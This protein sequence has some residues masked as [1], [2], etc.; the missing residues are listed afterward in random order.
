MHVVLFEPEIPANTGNI[1]RLCVGTGTK[2]HLIR[3]LG[4]FLTDRH[5]RR[6]GLDYW[7]YLDLKVHDSWDD[8]AAAV[9]TGRLYFVETGGKKL[10]TEPQYEAD[11]YFVFGSET[12]GLPTSILERWPDQIITIPQVKVRS[13]NLANTVAIVVYEAWRQLGFRMEG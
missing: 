12:K 10:Y 2:L 6:A 1:A 13:L 8:F 4:F 5:L 7:D 3:P 9:S 11:D